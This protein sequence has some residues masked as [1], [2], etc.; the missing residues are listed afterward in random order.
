MIRLAVVG[1]GGYGWDLVRL[2]N[3][4]SAHAGCR[5][6]AA[7]DN[8]LS[9]F[10]ERARELAEQGVELFDDALAMYRAMQG[11]CEA[12]YVAT[13]IGSHAKL[14]AE[15]L[16]AGFHVHL[17]KPPA[18]VVQ[19][20]D[21]MLQAVR[22]TGKMCLVGFQAVHGDDV[23]F[24]HDRVA[25]GRLGAVRSVAC[26]AGWPRTQEYYR[27]NEWAGKLQSGGAWVLDG[28]ATNALAHQ[29]T[30][31]LL[32]ASPAPGKLATPTGVRAELY[33]AGPVESHDTAAIEIRTAEGA[34]AYFIASHCSD[35]NFG[36]V[37]E[38]TAEGGKAV[39]ENG[40]AATVTYADGTQ[41][42]CPSDAR[43]R[44]KMVL[45]LLEAIRLGDA[46]MLR[47]P[48]EEAR[49]MV[50]ALDGAHESSGRIHR[51]GPAVARR[52]DEGTDKARTVVDG[53]DDLL[54][55]AARQRCLFSD[56]DP[57]PRWS[58]KTGA[59]DLTDY[60]EFPRRFQA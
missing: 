31:M 35:R 24:V 58:V 15:A 21:F 37:I 23:R 30:N 18:A 55:L 10:T 54:V 40:R 33:A 46:S 6:V 7:A 60:T 5:L 39:W 50:L 26:Y 22:E 27:R 53:L 9:D 13:S 41:E 59:F 51:I 19:D 32:M 48:L 3:D 12:V 2:I 17:E 45:N 14:T 11:K 44:L 36:P 52:V 8:R 1:I 20:V 4:A 47:C 57:A 34:K 42:T 38:L 28:P 29:I 43:N 25:A 49:K 16:R 56:L